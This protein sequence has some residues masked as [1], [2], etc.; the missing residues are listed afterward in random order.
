MDLKTFSNLSRVKD[1]GA[2]LVKHGF[3]DVVQRLELQ[4]LAEKIAP[5]AD[6]EMS[7]YERIRRALEDLGPTFIKLG[8]ILSMRPDMLPVPMTKELTRLQDDAAPIEFSAVKA[9]L[10]AELEGKLEDLFYAFDETPTAAA[11]LSQV[12][13]AVL[14]RDGPV[15]AVK[16]RRPGVSALIQTDLDIMETI[17]RRLHD[18]F[19]QLQLY[20]LPSIIR[21]SRRT[22]FR[23]IDFAKEARHIQI[24]R[25]KIG[26]DE[27]ILI[28]DV[29]MP[30]CTEK[31][32]A[33]EFVQ[34]RKIAA[35]S[36]SAEA[37]RKTL[38]TA[39]LRSGILQVLDYGFFHADPH[40]GNIVI[41]EDGRLCLMDWG[42]VGRLTEEERGD[43]LHLIRTMVD[44]DIPKMADILVKLAIVR[45]APN[46]QRLQKDL[47]D[48]L[49]SYVAIPLQEVRVGNLITDIITVI[50]EHRL[51]LPPDMSVVI[52]ALMTVEGTARLIY[53]QLDAVSEAEPHIR[54]LVSRQYTPG[55]VW[56]RL[57][58]HFSGIW[59]F[60]KRLPGRLSDILKQMEQGDLSFKFEHV[61]LEGFQKTLESIFNRLTL[62]VVLSAMIIGSS[63]IITTGVQPLLFGFPALGIIGYMISA[64]LGLWL[65]FTIIRGRDY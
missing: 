26:Q 36:E 51:R 7:V 6:L 17:A 18:N 48:I 2:V 10:E 4:G 28:P 16:V 46:M 23:E 3:G 31:V 65:I 30:Y 33:M 41:A 53:P 24:A 14:N 19:E 55:N 22:I 37:D 58:N 25:S 40:P 5:A 64:V 9:V 13:R 44:R 45:D 49:D 42:M 57:R 60:Q 35:L 50:K 56:R 63:M 47:M 1:I 61:N 21:V 27:D 8:Q 11:S 20:D 62:G 38:A 43:L 32:L 39:G 52:K 54:Q 12:H 15:L 34:G 59:A 29:Y